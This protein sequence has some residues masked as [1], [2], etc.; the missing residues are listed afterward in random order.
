MLRKHFAL[1]SYRQLSLSLRIHWKEQHKSTEEENIECNIYNLLKES[2][3]R[4]YKILEKN[5]NDLKS[6]A[7]KVFEYDTLN[8]NIF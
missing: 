8:C 4:V 2:H 1:C 6:L 3:D 5:A 7:Q